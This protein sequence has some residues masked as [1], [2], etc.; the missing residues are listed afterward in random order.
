[1]FDIGFFELLLIAVVGL[2]VFGP[3]QFLDAV[4]TTALW[5]KRARRSFDEVRAE[6]QRELHNDKIMRDLK[7]SA[8]KV[9]EELREVT[10]P[11]D[12]QVK[13]ADSG[14]RG[15]LQAINHSVDE[16]AADSQAAVASDA[17]TTNTQSNAEREHR[18]DGS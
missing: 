13:Q 14:M 1:M 6:V 12:Q 16:A 7:E 2:L 5:T 9:Q 3:E 15:T 10:A 18:G 17:A 8:N 11:L 4:R